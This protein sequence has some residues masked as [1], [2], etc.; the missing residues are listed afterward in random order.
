MG[1]KL[2][3]FHLE[4]RG[5]CPCQ[6]LNA[7]T[8]EKISILNMPGANSRRWERENLYGEDNREKRSV[9]MDKVRVQ[10]KWWT[11]IQLTSK[12][13]CKVCKILINASPNQLQLEKLNHANTCKMD[14]RAPIPAL[15]SQPGYC[16]FAWSTDSFFLRNHFP[17]QK[18]SFFPALLRKHA[19]F[20]LPTG[21][22]NNNKN[23]N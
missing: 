8:E 5:F 3:S 16:S 9:G 15:L 10:P 20:R 12:N 23:N 21:T 11:F 14:P 4:I 1:I 22:G 19:T 7:G 6:C 2:F 17:E 13:T 18:C